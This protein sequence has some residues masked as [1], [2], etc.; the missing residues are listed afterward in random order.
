M[1]YFEGLLDSGHT[2]K[3]Q[4]TSKEREK[5]KEAFINQKEV[6]NCLSLLKKLQKCPS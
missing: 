3:N 1:Q 5:L 6:S 2:P 4:E